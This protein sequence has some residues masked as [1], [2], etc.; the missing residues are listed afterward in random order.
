MSNKY[1]VDRRIFLVLAVGI[2]LVFILCFSVMA[3]ST[4]STSPNWNVS[5]KLVHNGISKKVYEIEIQNL[6]GNKRYFNLS[7]LFQQA[8]F[9]LDEIRNVKL[10]EWKPISKEFPVYDKINETINYTMEYR[11]NFT[12]PSNCWW[13]E[14]YS[15]FACNITKI[16]QN[17]T[18]VKKVL[19]WKPAKMNIVKSYFNKIAKPTGRLMHGDE[20]T[21]ISHFDSINIPKFNSECEYD[22][23]GQKYD[24]N[25]TKKFRLEFEVPITLTQNKW[26]SNGLV[27]IF[28]S[29]SLE[30]YHPWWNSS[31][32]YRR[33]I[34]IIEH[35]G[36]NLTDYQV[37]LDIDYDSDM[38][39]D[40]DDL[41]FT[42]LNESSG[43]EEEIPY[44][45]EEKIDGTSASVWIKI[46]H[47]P[48][49]GTATVYMYYGNPSV[50]DESNPDDVFEFFDDFEGTSLNTS[51]WNVISG[52]LGT[53]I[54]VS[55][56]TITIHR[57][58][59]SADHQP[60]INA[61]F[62]FGTNYIFEASMKYDGTATTKGGL[63][64]F[65][66]PTSY[67][68]PD[69]SSVYVYASTTSYR[70]QAQ[71]DGTYTYDN[72]NEEFPTYFEVMSIA[73]DSSSVKLYRNYILKDTITTNVPDAT[74]YL[75]L[76]EWGTGYIYADWARV[77]KYTDPEPTYEIG[78]EETPSDSTPPNVDFVSQNPADVDTI[79]ILSNDL[80]ITYNITDNFGVN[81]S[82]V[83]MYYK[84]NS[85]HSDTVW[86]VNGSA[87]SGWQATTG[88]QSGDLWNFMLDH[89]VYPGIY[90]IDD[91]VM[92]SET[93]HD[94]T[95][96][97]SSKILKIRF[98][99]ITDDKQYNYLVLDAENVS[100]GSGFLRI[101]YCNESYTTGDPE[102]NDNCIEFYDLQPGTAYNYTIGSSTYWIIPMGIDNTTGYLAN[103]KITN[104]SYILL[105]D[106]A[107]NS[108]WKV[109]YIT[110]ITRDDQVQYSGN[111]GLSYSNFAGTVDMHIH[112]FCGTDKL[113]YYVCANDTA[114]NENCSAVRYDLLQL[115]G[116][117]PTSPDVYSPLEGIY[118]GNININYRES[119]SP[120][121]YD[122]DYYNIT[123]VDLGLSVV[124]VIKSNNSL[125]LSYVWDSTEVPDGEYF[126]R[127]EAVDELGQ[128]SYGYSENVTIDNNAPMVTIVS[129]SNSTYHTDNIALN[130]NVDDVTTDSC[131]YSLDG[132]SNVVLTG[133]SN[134]TLSSL[135]CGNHH[136]VVYA[137]DS[138][139]RIG[140]DDVYF[141]VNCA[142]TTPTI[143]FSPH[144]VITGDLLTVVA[145]STDPNGDTITYYYRYEDSNG[146][147]LRDYSTNDTYYI[148][149][150]LEGHT[151]VVK[152]IAGDG[153][154]NSTENSSSIKVASLSIISPTLDEKF[155][156]KDI[157]F[158]FNL[159]VENYLTC[160]E[161]IDGTTYSLGNVTDGVHTHVREVWYGNHTYTITCFSLY[162]SHNISRNISNFY[163]S[164]AQWNIT[165]YNENDWNMLFNISKTNE[166]SLYVFCEGGSQTIYNLTNPYV[167]IE[168]LCDV[169]TMMVKV[170]YTSDSYTRE[171]T[172]PDDRTGD[173]S[174]YLVDAYTYTLLQ[175]PLYITDSN[176]YDARIMLYKTNG[177]TVYTITDGYFDIEHKFVTYLI[178]D[179]RYYVR[180]IKG[181][182]V[183]D[184]GF[185]YT[186]ST[187][188]QYI[189]LSQISLTPDVTTI[190]G[191]VGLSAY[192]DNSTNSLIIQYVDK[193]NGTE[194]VTISVFDSTN[195]TPIFN[196][197]YGGVSNLMITINNVSNE[198][199]YNVIAEVKH[200]TLGDFELLTSAGMIVSN[201]FDLGLAPWLYPIISFGIIIFT[202]FI[203]VPRNRLVGLLVISGMIG[204]FAVV[205]WLPVYS[206]GVSVLI[207]IAIGIG[208]IYEMK[209]G[210]M[211]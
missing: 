21:L 195:N 3:I 80:N 84:T 43:N 104:T 147:L 89:Q 20:E 128:S 101:Y 182:E 31:W 126:I 211:E 95:L 208:W 16:V 189:S 106:S 23:F 57:I 161:T 162:D 56:G 100:G 13:I 114:G 53:E 122:I 51:K 156:T 191:N 144:S 10:Y 4:S 197:T 207:L 52:N 142:P 173:V 180:I 206:L 204:M 54:V 35:S 14:E 30:Y 42:W 92:E 86:F 179:S 93:K 87:V 24:C 105:R 68:T 97:T 125:D 190:G 9:P 58:D 127:V 15:A 124:H 2:M 139:G 187:A 49:S 198:T 63:F 109:S 76:R 11:I 82:T 192:Y 200:D 33:S 60:N 6:D 175:I 18:V 170:D 133:C 66:S 69:S 67:D 153:H 188:A 130:Y 25:G 107:S 27:G 210:G 141:Y 36:K 164:Y 72:I 91:S 88:T 136:V 129:P 12:L 90:N 150:Y 1:K 123:L 174:I 37:L 202:S 59:T 112:Q 5:W 205:G 137:N 74:L 71:N 29:D 151:I 47:I 140:S 62:G 48:A 177:S 38:Q 152:V 184:I 115:A 171:R 203:I 145:S 132:G 96:T 143:S 110:N 17:G 78:A 193:L 94:F 176:Y 64:T 8:N 83:F 154:L 65:D 79:N 178:K 50:T 46:P 44:W 26:G 45:I 158:T 108:D 157:N 113:W 75:N 196:N 81:A 19:D 117:P 181:S 32:N 55:S 111:G 131:W 70:F 201:L 77:R 40:F 121:G 163:N 209:R 34:T 22:D 39:S 185:L 103:V 169:S 165:L 155:T 167:Y 159:T 120:N 160:Q 186:A 194:N 135:S 98:F 168:P 119:I 166:T 28:D 134:T 61:K 7:V 116:L 146:T 172:P 118:S 102:T 41:R 199:R 85:T 148:N 149:D 183:R 138:F 73:R 99:N